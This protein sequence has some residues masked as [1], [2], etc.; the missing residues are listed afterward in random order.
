LAMHSCC[1]N[2]A[3]EGKLGG[4]HYGNIIAP[5]LLCKKGPTCLPLY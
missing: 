2:N 3:N 5:A 1:K 4:K